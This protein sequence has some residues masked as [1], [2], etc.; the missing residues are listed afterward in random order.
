M[1]ELGIER[2]TKKKRMDYNGQEIKEKGKAGCIKNIDAV[3]Q[4][5]EKKKMTLGKV[6]YLLDKKKNTIIFIDRRGNETLAIE[7]PLARTDLVGEA[8]TAWD[9]KIKAILELDPKHALNEAE[10]DS[11]DELLT[12]F[13]TDTCKARTNAAKQNAEAFIQSKSMSKEDKT[14][15][16]YLLSAL[17]EMQALE[18]KAIQKQA[19]SKVEIEN[20]ELGEF[21]LVDKAESLMTSFDATIDKYVDKAL[22][23]VGQ[24]FDKKDDGFFEYV[25]YLVAESKFEAEIALSREI[26]IQTVEAKAKHDGVVVMNAEGLE[27]D[28]WEEE[29]WYQHGFAGKLDDYKQKLE[30]QLSA[31]QEEAKQIPVAAEKAEKSGVAIFKNLFKGN[32]AKNGAKN[33]EKTKQAIQDRK[34][35]AIPIS[36]F[37][38][39]KRFF[40]LT[41]TP[42][43]SMRALFLGTKVSKLGDDA[44]ETQFARE[45][46][47]ELQEKVLTAKIKRVIRRIN[48][49]K[50]IQQQVKEKEKEASDKTKA[51]YADIKGVEGSNTELA[52]EAEDKTK[53]LN[54]FA[55]KTGQLGGIQAKVEENLEK[56]SAK[57]DGLQQSEG[58]WTALAEAQKNELS[59][60]SRTY[61]TEQG[62]LE[63]E[64][65]ELKEKVSDVS[66]W[67][68]SHELQL[69]EQEKALKDVDGVNDS[70]VPLFVR[71]TMSDFCDAA[72]GLVAQI[73]LS[74]AEVSKKAEE[75]RASVDLAV[76]DAVVNTAMALLH[77]EASVSIVYR[78]NI[79]FDPKVGE[80]AVAYD[81]ASKELKYRYVGANGVVEESLTIGKNEDIKLLLTFLNN[82]STE[83]KVKFL[84][85]ATFSTFKTAYDVVLAAKKVEIDAK[86]ASN[87][88]QI[89]LTLGAIDL[90][91]SS[92][93]IMGSLAD[94]LSEEEGQTLGQRLK[95]LIGPQNGNGAARLKELE[96]ALVTLN[97]QNNA[98][99]DLKKSIVAQKTELDAVGRGQAEASA[100]QASLE[101]NQIGQLQNQL[102]LSAIRVGEA[103]NQLKF[104]M[105][106]GK[107]E[108][109]HNQ[110]FTEDDSKKLRNVIAQAKR[111]ANGAGINGVVTMLNDGTSQGKAVSEKLQ[112]ELKNIDWS[113]I[114]WH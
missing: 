74:L 88:E 68:K 69:K 113:K 73:T 48:I 47:L 26:K 111:N 104:S 20:I 96:A 9:A 15:V 35:Q 1:D 59:E 19:K 14:K 51:V 71:S 41:P 97:T 109:E 95:V 33:K 53:A 62:H 94:C 56:L 45:D 81:A 105:Q 98:I 25:T 110:F 55:E 31:L 85:A 82:Q 77:V 28:N 78:I 8:K 24:G 91:Q 3:I 108:T 92:E 107:A 38:R 57:A 10:I 100:L 70:L 93:T 54:D 16:E 43:M 6:A 86:E 89:K 66:N 4:G 90:T 72:T 84:N 2:D 76:K 102:R 5:L 27:Q 40:N 114:Q 44:V 13:G 63:T 46:K 49:V 21:G 12:S 65:S 58:V 29:A 99:D 32:A 101:K 61:A 7:I 34:K 22:S 42:H 79:G 112:A 80:I 103:M 52:K 36:L 64:L 87:K 83:N 23:A 30:A 50:G 11:I 106:E 17:Q 37:E 60:L 39:F 75:A 67:T 18:V